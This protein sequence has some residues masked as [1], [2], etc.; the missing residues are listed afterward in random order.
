MKTV[1]RMRKKF[2]VMKTKV[3]R[4]FFEQYFKK[5][6]MKIFFI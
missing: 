6:K 1:R 5:K 4:K 2:G 3:G